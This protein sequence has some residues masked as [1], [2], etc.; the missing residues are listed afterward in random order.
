[1]KP[2]REK[3]FPVPTHEFPVPGN[4]IPC[5][6]GLRELAFKPLIYMI[7]WTRKTPKRAASGKI[8]C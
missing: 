7:D 1:M 4:K 2:I 8:P 3:E 5:S 6:F